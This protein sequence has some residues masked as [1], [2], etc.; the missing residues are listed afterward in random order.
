MHYH[1]H[2]NSL[3][4][5]GTVEH[6]AEPQSIAWLVFKWCSAMLF[7]VEVTLFVARLCAVGRVV[8]FLPASPL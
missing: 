4:V 3:I 7:I 2:C 5:V 8:K 6:V 1:Y